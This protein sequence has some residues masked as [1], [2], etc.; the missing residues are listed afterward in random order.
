MES[1][2]GQRSDS[3]DPSEPLAAS[4][5]GERL[6][7]A[8]PEDVLVLHPFLMLD[9]AWWEQVRRLLQLA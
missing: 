9:E 3:G 1:F 8:G 5:L 7:Q 6:A 2:A 4:A